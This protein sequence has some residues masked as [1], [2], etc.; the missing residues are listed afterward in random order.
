MTD[1]VLQVVFPGTHV[2]YVARDK[3]ALSV[4]HALGKSALVLAAISPLFLSIAFHLTVNKVTVVNLLLLCEEVL[5]IAMELTVLETT[6]KVAAISPSK[7]AL[8]RLDI[9]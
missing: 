9:H 7:F 5:S 1:S 4:L 8:A 3:H 6:L 2:D